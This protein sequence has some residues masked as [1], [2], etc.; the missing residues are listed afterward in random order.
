MRLSGL[1]LTTKKFQTDE[2]H[3]SNEDDAESWSVFGRGSHA[4][5]LDRL[6]IMPQSS[7][8]QPSSRALAKQMLGF[9]RHTPS[10][11]GSQGKDAMHDGWFRDARLKEKSGPEA[12]LEHAWQ[13][14]HSA[15][16]EPIKGLFVF[17]MQCKDGYPLNPGPRGGLGNEAA[18]RRWRRHF[19]D[20]RA[21]APD[22]VAVT[23]ATRR[24]ASDTSGE[25]LV[26]F[27]SSDS[28]CEVTM[29]VP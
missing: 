18:V 6:H 14:A 3:A 20:L 12:R 17:S 28:T 5:I 15:V 10:V 29:L 19:S 23:S 16:L 24:R 11:H 7:L 27:D 13:L 25:C 8:L 4:K 22:A 2:G 9:S 26:T 21:A 1:E